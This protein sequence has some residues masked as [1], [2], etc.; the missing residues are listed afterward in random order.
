M[1]KEEGKAFD[2]NTEETTQKVLEVGTSTNETKIDDKTSFENFKVLYD[3]RIKEKCLADY[4]TIEDKE[5]LEDTA[6]ELYLTSQEL[7]P[8]EDTK[9]EGDL[10][11][12][13]TKQEES[14]KLTEIV[15]KELVDKMDKNEFTDLYY[16]SEHIDDIEKVIDN[17]TD[18]SKIKQY[19]EILKAARAFKSG[20]TKTESLSNE[21]KF[22]AHILNGVIS[23]VQNKFNVTATGELDTGNKNKVV[24]TLK[25]STLDLIDATSYLA[26]A[27]RRDDVD[28]TF[29]DEIKNNTVR[30]VI[31]PKTKTE[32]KDNEGSEYDYMLLSRLKS[33]CDYFLGNGNRYEKHLWAGNI[34][35]QIAKM[36]ELYNKLPEKPEWLTMEDIENYEKEMKSDDKINESV[37]EEDKFFNLYQSFDNL[38]GINKM[39]PKELIE[40]INDLKKMNRISDKDFNIMNNY[41]NK[42][43]DLINKTGYASN[44]A[45]ESKSVKKEARDRVAENLPKFVYDLTKSDFDKYGETAWT[46]S[47]PKKDNNGRTVYEVYRNG[48]SD[49]K[50]ADVVAEIQKEFPELK[51]SLQSTAPGDR[52]FF[53]KETKKQESQSTEVGYNEFTEDMEEIERTINFIKEPKNKDAK[54]VL[55]DVKEFLNKLWAD[56]EQN[57]FGIKYAENKKIEESIKDKNTETQNDILDYM[58]AECDFKVYSDGKAE[59]TYIPDLDDVQ[60]YVYE[61]ATQEDVD[62]VSKQLEDLITNARF[63][64][65][66]GE[67][68][69]QLNDNRTLYDI[70]NDNVD[71]QLYNDLLEPYFDAFEED[72]GVQ[73]YQAGR[74]G[75]HIVIKFNLENLENYD[76]LKAEQEKQERAFIEEVNNYGKEEESKDVE[77]TN[78]NKIDDI[79]AQLMEE[80][81]DF[82]QGYRD[83]IMELGLSKEDFIDMITTENEHQLLKDKN[84]TEDEEKEVYGKIYDTLV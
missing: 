81:P 64:K 10:E 34:D 61:D 15:S 60:R 83:I 66:D 26:K 63:Y 49:F 20:R 73:L 39:N 8:D 54:E 33:D 30:C 77:E 76:A 28:F 43:Q 29:D 4:G 31:S 19:K 51:L 67:L 14:V 5:L 41:A 78:T 75:R 7:I 69:I 17:C 6:K 55:D 37:L 44:T 52:V 59:V 57:T 32:S 72:T 58:L 22:L 16:F 3:G 38:Y 82:A 68:Y 71:E 24:V 11:E 25:G 48:K 45:D 18:K 42:W 12:E 21:S 74:S 2:L 35:D 80:L 53:V 23:D 47:E 13:K 50:I 9:S 70:D 79:V 65:E 36:K 1:K 46:A 56:K 27:I 40:F 84:I 62:K